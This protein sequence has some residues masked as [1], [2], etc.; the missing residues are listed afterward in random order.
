VLPAIK[1]ERKVTNSLDDDAEPVA[2]VNDSDA[3]WHPSTV[4]RGCSTPNRCFAL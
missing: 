3:L 4:A 1:D 2:Y